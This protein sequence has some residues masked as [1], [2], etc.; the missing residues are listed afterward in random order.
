MRVRS[1]HGEGSPR[2]KIAA[3]PVALARKIRASNARGRRNHL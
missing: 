1:G 3:T 2:W